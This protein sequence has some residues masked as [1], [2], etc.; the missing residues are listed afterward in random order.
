VVRNVKNYNLPKSFNKPE[1]VQPLEHK[2]KWQVILP[3]GMLV[4]CNKGTRD[5]T[6]RIQNDTPAFASRPC[7][8]CTSLNNFERDAHDLLLF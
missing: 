7:G 3:N 8:Y 1:E 5:S 2:W 4:K 6:K